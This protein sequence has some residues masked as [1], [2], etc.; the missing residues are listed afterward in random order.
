MPI[1]L[2]QEDPAGINMTPMVDVLFT[3]IIFF[4]VGANFNDEQRQLNVQLP[5]VQAAGSSSGNVPPRTI[6]VE[7]NGGVFLDEESVSLEQLTEKIRRNGLEQRQRVSIQGDAMV[8]FQSI[9]SVLSATR[10]AGIHDMSIAVRIE[11]ARR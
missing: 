4:M 10:M 2:R 1:R 5:T 6:R 8:P 7:A 3:L 9:A 11:G